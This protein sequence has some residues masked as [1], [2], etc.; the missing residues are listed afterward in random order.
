VS[1]TDSIDPAQYFKK[2]KQRDAELAKLT[3]KGEVQFVP[4]LMLEVDTT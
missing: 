3:S 4:P 1:L 2:L